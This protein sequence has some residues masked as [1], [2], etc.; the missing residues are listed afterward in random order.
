MDIQPEFVVSANAI[1]GG[2]NNLVCH[3]AGGRRGVNADEFKSAGL[4]EK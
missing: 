1:I 3:K 4:H 2:K